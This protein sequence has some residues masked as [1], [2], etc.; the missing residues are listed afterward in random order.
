MPILCDIVDKMSVHSLVLYGVALC[1]RSFGFTMSDHH[2]HQCFP[3]HTSATPFAYLLCTCINHALIM[4]IIYILTVTA[5]IYWPGRTV[6][7]VNKDT[8]RGAELD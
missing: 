7:H 3:V 1:V 4:T 5:S 6:T 8:M 2:H